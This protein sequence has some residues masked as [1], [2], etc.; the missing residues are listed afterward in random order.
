MLV[1]IS[2]KN[3]LSFKDKVTFSLLWKNNVDLPNN[4]YEYKKDKILKSAIIYGHNSSW[5]TNLLKAI[6]FIKNIIV[7][8]YKIWPNEPIN[9]FVTSPLDFFRFSSDTRNT[10]TEFEINFIIKEVEYRYKFSLDNLKIISEELFSK[11][12]QK[13][14]KLYT[15]NYQEIILYDF[16]DNNSVSRVLDNTLAISVFAKENSEEA[17]SIH[18]FFRNIHV[19]FAN[20]NTQDTI[21]MLKRDAF[22]ADESK[23]FKT[24]LNGLL[25]K[26]D[27]W[28]EWFRY[29]ITKQPL[30]SLPNEIKW[31]LLNQNQIP[32]PLEFEQVDFRFEH[33]VY[34]NFHNKIWIEF[35]W[36][37]KE[38]D[39][40]NKFLNL[41]WSIF[42][43]MKEWKILF[44][45]E[46]ESSLHPVLQ[47]YVIDIFH[48]S[49]YEKNFQVVFTTHNTKL[50]NIQDIFRRDQIWFVEKDK[51]WHSSINSLSD[52]K[53][54]VRKDTIVEK[55]YYRWM[56]WWISKLGLNTTEDF[57]N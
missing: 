28:V 18:N 41:A 49:K 32:V 24:F 38:S 47:E 34:D 8:W 29:S 15:R 17:K 43:V 55:N 19:F 42:N 20:V 14:K 26:A 35:F 36:H 46:I 45:D 4:Y 1:D 56:Y 39:W 21:E 50:M 54:K 3:Y 51:F 33:T 25:K 31:F 5:K 13:E 23:K 9:W 53:E 30:E 44:I 57:P 16:D 6:D 11:K 22:E 37:E 40:T 10:P 12:T 2:I 7:E 27:L 52:Q 48:N